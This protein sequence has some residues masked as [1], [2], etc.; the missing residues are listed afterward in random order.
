MI[1]TQLNP[2]N[3]FHHRQF[4]GEDCIQSLVK[5]DQEV[6]FVVACFERTY[7]LFHTFFQFG[8]CSLEFI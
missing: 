3:H 6:K 7:L 4:I 1:L 5:S 8:D 2:R